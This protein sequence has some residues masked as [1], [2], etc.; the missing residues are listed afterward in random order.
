MMMN[1][2]AAIVSMP[3]GR[4]PAGSE[5]ALPAASAAASASFGQTLV[6]HIGAGNGKAAGA[7]TSAAGPL[8]ALVPATAAGQPDESVTLDMLLGQIADLLEQ[9]EEQSPIADNGTGEEL[10]ASYEQAFEQLE[11]LLALLGIQPEAYPAPPAA[12]YAQLADG[13]AAAPSGRTEAEW[14]TL[15]LNIGEALLQLQSSLESGTARMGHRETYALI[16]GQLQKL[17]GLLFEN[18]AAGQTGP[19]GQA[20]QAGPAGEAP[21]A[22]DVSAERQSR[23]PHV[24]IEAPIRLQPAE[25]SPGPTVA[26]AA[27]EQTDGS[28]LLRR[29]AQQPVQPNVL[30]AVVAASGGTQQTEEPTPPAETFGQPAQLPAANS[31]AA[32]GQ[33]PA[34][35]FAPKAETPVYIPATKFADTMNT[36]IVQRFD[37]TLAQGR[38]EARLSLSPEHLGQLEVKLTVR[39]GQLAAQFVTDTPMAKEML[40]SQLPQLRAALQQQGLQ[41]DSLDVTYRDGDG[42]SSELD[43]RQHDRGHGRDDRSVGRD[44]TDGSFSEENAFEAEL[45]EL[46][47]KRELGYGRA[48]SV[49]A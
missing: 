46:N 23:Q 11:A 45:A 3:V 7:E 33:R 12:A 20:G 40:D 30:A 29:L 22:G 15:Q 27:Q 48:I 44:G 5:S 8:A 21:Y 10:F 49:T 36:Y 13:T 25:P 47:I 41:V 17:Q 38:S 32:E 39:K 2:P 6:Y 9:L 26:I 4:T 42:F 16:A 34:A 1:I 43:S 24:R 28:R 14:R 18:G 31:V 37:I 19:A 35:A